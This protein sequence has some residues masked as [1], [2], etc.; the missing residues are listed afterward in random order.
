MTC[1][2]GNDRLSLVVRKGQTVLAD[3]LGRVL[4]QI[5]SP[6]RPRANE[7][8]CRQLDVAP[9]HGQDVVVDPAGNAFSV[10]VHLTQHLRVHQ[11]IAKLE[12]MVT[13]EYSTRVQHSSVST[14]V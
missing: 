1:T 4:D 14:A 10:R 2:L 6:M 12:A 13:G 9:R 5:P 7:E 11:R 8:L 3:E